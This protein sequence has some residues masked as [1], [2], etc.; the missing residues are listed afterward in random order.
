MTDKEVSDVVN[1]VFM[2]LGAWSMVSG[3]MWN[4]PIAMNI[5]PASTLTMPKHSGLLNAGHVARSPTPKTAEAIITRMAIHLLAINHPFSSATTLTWPSGSSSPWSWLWSRAMSSRVRPPSL[6]S[7][8]WNAGPWRSA[9]IGVGE[10]IGS[11]ESFGTKAGALGRS[12]SEAGAVSDACSAPPGRRS[13]AISRACVTACSKAVR[14]TSNASTASWAERLAWA[15][16]TAAAAVRFA[17]CLAALSAVRF[18]FAS[19]LSSLRLLSSPNSTKAASAL[20]IASFAATASFSAN[21]ALRL[22]AAAKRSAS[23]AF[24]TNLSS[25]KSASSSIC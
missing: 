10:A 1:I 17:L 7:L 14:F 24:L 15:A 3:K 13:A 12:P 19:R 23:V 5:P 21:V 6:Y 9:G 25:F 22:A 2:L 8:R 18:A 4:M 11:A 16:A 20:N